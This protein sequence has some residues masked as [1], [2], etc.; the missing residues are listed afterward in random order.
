MGSYSY[1]FLDIFL[2]ILYLFEFPIILDDIDLV[3][4]L[5]DYFPWHPPIYVTFSGFYTICVFVDFEKKNSD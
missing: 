2:E 5:Y 1:D 3:F 4:Y